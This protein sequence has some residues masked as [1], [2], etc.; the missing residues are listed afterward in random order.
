MFGQ[1]LGIDTISYTKINRTR[2]NNYPTCTLYTA[3]YNRVLLI[4]LVWMVSQLL[5][6]LES[7]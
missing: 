7:D 1:N 5:K 3:F 6:C 4:Q 2:F